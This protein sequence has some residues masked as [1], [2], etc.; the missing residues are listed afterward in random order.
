MIKKSIGVLTFVFC[1][2]M[3]IASAHA[4]P[5]YKTETV[6]NTLKQ[7]HGEIR[8]HEGVANGNLIVIYVSPQGSFT[9]VLQRP[10]GTSC[11]M[12]AGNNWMTSKGGS[13]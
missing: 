12:E 7:K 13:I 8:A 3:A 1:F 9:V 5:C 11:L 6:E 10:N 2:L 4:G